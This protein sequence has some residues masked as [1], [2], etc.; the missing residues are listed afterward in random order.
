MLVAALVCAGLCGCST[1]YN[2]K[3]LADQDVGKALDSAE[4]TLADHES[5]WGSDNELVAIDAFV[6]GEAA[7]RAGEYPKARKAFEK[8]LG[9]YRKQGDGKNKNVYTTIG[10]LGMVDY[11]EGKFDEAEARF[12][13]S[14]AGTAAVE[15]PDDAAV[16]KQHAN[17]AM[18]YSERGRYVEAKAEA[19]RALD[20][21][22]KSEGPKSQQTAQAKINLATVH[23]QLGEWAPAKTLL[24]EALVVRVDKYG[25]DHHETALVLANLGVLYAGLGDQAKAG[26]YSQK[27]IVGLEKAYGSDHPMVIT[28]RS[29][30]GVTQFN[31]GQKDEALATSKRALADAEKR[32]G[33]EH[34]DT[35]IRRQNY[36]LDLIAAG[37][38]AEGVE[39][40]K[41]SIALMEKTRGL[42]H[43]WLARMY[44]NLGGGL[45]LAGKTDEAMPHLD[46]S[47]A[48]AVK[49]LGPN[50]EFT[51]DAYRMLGIAHG[52]AKRCTQSMDAFLKGQ[53]VDDGLIDAVLG[54]ADEER[55]LSFLRTNRNAM[56]M[57]FS[58]LLCETR[59]TP[60]QV[61]KVLEV[62]LKRKGAVLEAQKRFQEALLYSDDPAV[63]KDL[64]ELSTVRGELSRLTLAGAPQD[65]PEAFQ[66]NVAGLKARREA[67]EKR[68]VKAGHAAGGQALL[69]PNV[70]SVRAALPPGATLVELCRMSQFSMRSYNA[71][72]DRYIAFVLP[73]SGPPVLR[74]LGEVLGIETEIG[75]MR[76]LIAEGAVDPRRNEAELTKLRAS[77]HKRLIAP[78]GVDAA[79]TLVLSPDG[80]LNFIPFEILLDGSGRVFL[81]GR[82][83]VYVSAGRDVLGFGKSPASKNPA[84]LMGDPDFDS[85]SGGKPSASGLRGTRAARSLRNVAFARLPGAGEELAALSGVVAGAKVFTGKEANETRLFELQS[86]GILH[87]ATHGFFLPDEPA[88]PVKLDA[89]GRETPAG[90]VPA[91]SAEAESPLSR[92]G[93][94]LSGANAALKTGGDE[95]VVTAE[96]ALRLKLKGTRLVVLSACETGLGRA[97]SGE[98]VF[99]LRRA[100]HQTG[101]KGVVMSLWSVPDRETSKLMQAFYKRLAAGDAPPK[102][103]R[104]ASL[105]LK[106]ALGANEHPFAWG[107]FIYVGEP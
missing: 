102:A 81:E 50:H 24:E 51:S 20:V 25:E 10:A 71:D 83:L 9:V 78:L 89:V 99:G 59:R 42:D 72:V 2:I 66:K 39:E 73:K 80:A 22:L 43:P 62:W 35:A 23:M 12:K 104:S 19:K 4:K 17:L 8:S 77:L 53:A 85:A 74:D 16:G 60:E 106:T 31:R 1:L 67:V 32:L 100:L 30:L 3:L 84:V 97:M 15:G 58:A 70:E 52:G 96:K 86:P 88:G 93:F 13:E 69:R 82:E 56:D 46:K 61:G 95:G 103:L 34:P 107:A 68:L 63:Q 41:R 98:G 90:A 64:V 105:E 57:L 101:A 40:A 48:V 45:A 37:R 36:A 27:A 6:L 94:V 49:S 47:L 55:K 79:K 33:A 5:T 18:L 14:L 26:E 11:H 28:V 75:R 87:L 65:K 54:F 76:E 29:N 44:G 21:L 38:T 91:P 7:R 92:S